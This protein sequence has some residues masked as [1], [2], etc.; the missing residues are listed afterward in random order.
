MEKEQ[1]MYSFKGLVGMAPTVANMTAVRDVFANELGLA[2]CRKELN[3]H[4]REVLRDRAQ[5]RNQAFYAHDYCMVHGHD[6][7]I[8]PGYRRLWEEGVDCPV[9]CTRCGEWDF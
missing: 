7:K 6:M 9:A 3:E 5:A 4:I 2:D 8:A 1:A